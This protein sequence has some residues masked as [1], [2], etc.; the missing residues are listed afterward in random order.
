MDDLSF[1]KWIALGGRRFQFEITQ[2]AIHAYTRSGNNIGSLWFRPKA[3]TWDDAGKAA[4]FFVD[5]MEISKEY[6]D[7]GIGT[8]MLTELKRMLKERYPS[9]K[10]VSAD[11]TSQGIAALMGRVFGPMVSAKGPEIPARS[12][13]DWIRTSVRQRVKFRVV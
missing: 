5:S 1:K 2:D 8:A 7:Q 11:A 3:T 10:F 12:P 13:D 9:V 4:T 6:Q